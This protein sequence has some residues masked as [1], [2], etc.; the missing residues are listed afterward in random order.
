MCRASWSVSTPLD[1]LPS[2]RKIIK[3]DSHSWVKLRI[4]FSAFSLEDIISVELCLQTSCR[5]LAS[6][7]GVVEIVCWENYVTV[8]SDSSRA[9][10]LVLICYSVPAVVR[11]SER[12]DM[13]V[14]S[15][16]VV[17]KTAMEKTEIIK[18]IFERMLVDD[19]SWAESVGARKRILE[20]NVVLEVG[21][22]VLTERSYLLTKHHLYL[23]PA[24]ILE[25]LIIKYEPSYSTLVYR[26]LFN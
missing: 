3:R 13:L 2:I 7:S 20:L 22:I 23:Y 1:S 25:L 16:S 24:L 14:S 26:S 18:K 8:V 11:R 12:A 4:L 17:G 19:T 5:F 10:C 15:A 21:G 6:L 9:Q